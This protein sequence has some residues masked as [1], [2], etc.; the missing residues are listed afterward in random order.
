MPTDDISARMV[1]TTLDST[2]HM[3]TSSPYGPVH[4]NCPF[5]EPLGNTPT[6]WEHRCLNG[7][8]NWMSTS[9]P[10]TTYSQLQH[11]ISSNQSQGFMA[12]VV[13]LVQGAKRG[14]L[15]LGA[16]HTEDDI[17]AALLL[18]KHLSWPVVPGI[19]SGL[20]LR[21]YM[22][23]FSEIEENIIFLDHLDQLLLSDAVKDWIQ[24]DVIIQVF[25]FWLHC[26]NNCYIT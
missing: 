12:E 9:E 8:E 22:A 26:I 25:L 10:F 4:I 1:L 11:S 6:I 20:R 17:W 24:A 2:S 16:L 7:L 19:L 23:S 18:A 21:K 15:V 3:A 13:K 5:R 14:L